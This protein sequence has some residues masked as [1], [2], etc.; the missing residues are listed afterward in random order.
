MVDME[1]A[2]TLQFVE[3]TR[4]IARECRALGLATPS[5]RSPPR[6]D[7]VDRTIW[8]RQDHSTIAVRV[9][10]RALA[11]VLADMVD[12]VLAANRLAGPEARTART[13]LWEAVAPLVTPP[14]PVVPVRPSLRAVPRAA[15]A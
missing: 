13:S 12:G 14:A 10:G 11:A 8:R 7:G 4:V 3:A 1:T 9:R 5:F 15:A 2:T 6:L